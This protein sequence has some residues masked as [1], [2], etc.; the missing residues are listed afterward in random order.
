MVRQN[1]PAS[2]VK[3]R[4]DRW[5][6]GPL[7]DSATVQRRGLWFGGAPIASRWRGKNEQFVP[8]RPS[9]KVAEPPLVT[10]G[11]W[12]GGVRGCCDTLA[13]MQVVDETIG[14]IPRAILIVLPVDFANDLTTVMRRAKA[15][16]SYG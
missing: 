14:A 11:G 13:R 10:L 5:G 12:G 9:A 6:D 2:I 1:H 3:K 4:A 8:F 7:H 15:G 16:A